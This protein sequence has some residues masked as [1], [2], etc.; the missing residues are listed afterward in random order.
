MRRFLALALLLSSARAA[1]YP[2]SGKWHY[3]SGEVQQLGAPVTLRGVTVQPM[4][5]MLGGQ[6]ISEDLLEFRG[7]ALLLRGIRVGKRLT[8]FLPPL[9]VYPASP[10]SPGQS[11]Q[12]V[13]STPGG[14]ATLRSTVL[15]SQPV[16][17]PAGKFNA[18]LIRSEL[19]QGKALSVQLSAFVPGLGV[20][21][22]QSEGGNVDLVSGGA[23]G[24]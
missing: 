9:I 10:L 4:R 22:Y 18:L 16:N 21:R 15:E 12:S 5:H 7:G 13:S 3:S 2:Q 1:Y 11:W 24:N 20:V 8:W 6:T 17:T 14:A 19:Q 23:D